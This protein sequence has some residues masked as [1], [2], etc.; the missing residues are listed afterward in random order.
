MCIILFKLMFIRV[1][2]LPIL[3]FLSEDHHL[4]KIVVL[5][6]NCEEDRNRFASE[7]YPADPI[8]QENS[9]S[10]WVMVACTSFCWFITAESKKSGTKRFRIGKRLWMCCILKRKYIINPWHSKL[11]PIINEKGA[12]LGLIG[13]PVKI[14]SGPAAVIPP[15][16]KEKG[17]LPAVVCHCS[18]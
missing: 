5:C 9:G 7:F 16:S 15:F 4:F 13:N 17:T 1:H 2:A 11:L 18:V 14:G 12:H 6:L 8:G 3:Y 10:L